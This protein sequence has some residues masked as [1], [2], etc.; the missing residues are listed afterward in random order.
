VSNGWLNFWTKTNPNTVI[1]LYLLSTVV[2]SLIV[3]VLFD[4]VLTAVWTRN[5]EVFSDRYQDTH[6]RYTW[7]LTT[8][9][10]L[11]VIAWRTV[12]RY[13]RDRQATGGRVLIARWGGLGWIV[14]V[15]MIMTAPWL[16]LWGNDRPVVQLNGQCAYI[17]VER[18][19]G[20]VI[21]QPKLKKTESY[22]KPPL[23]LVRKNIEGY[24]FAEEDPCEKKEE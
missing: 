7:A 20:L 6:V 4:A 22:P 5:T 24:V 8:L 19:E 2:V 15:V 13:L 10:T 3:I 12:L 17:L 16:L 1:E 9:A 18:A 21:Y 23:G 14:V 11:L